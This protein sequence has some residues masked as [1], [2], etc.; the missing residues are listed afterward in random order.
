MRGIPVFANCIEEPCNVGFFIQ[1]YQGLRPFLGLSRYRRQISEPQ[2][3]SDPR[4]VS[5]SDE[6]GT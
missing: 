2:P 6:P 4:R 1:K 3:G 5:S